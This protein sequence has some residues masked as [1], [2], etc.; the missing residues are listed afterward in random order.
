MISADFV[1]KASWVTDPHPIE[2]CSLQPWLKVC[3][4]IVSS[5]PSLCFSPSESDAIVHFAAAGSTYLQ[6][7]QRSIH[8]NFLRQA[9]T[10]VRSSLSYPYVQELRKRHGLIGLVFYYWD[11]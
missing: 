11:G 3:L 7:K 6:K 2:Q 4:L 8:Y 5:L 9:S 1:G 10:P